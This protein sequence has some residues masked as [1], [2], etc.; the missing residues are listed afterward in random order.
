MSLTVYLGRRS[1]GTLAPTD[2]TGQ[3]SFTYQAEAIDAADNRLS[4]SLPVRKA[5]FSPMESRPFF[6]GLLPERGVR[7]TIAARLRVSAENSYRLLRELGR[8]CAGAVVVL[9]EE[10]ALEPAAGGVEW[11][12]EKDLVAL[13]EEL[14]R[15]PL[16]VSGDRRVRLSLAGLQRKAVLIR[17]A[18]GEFGLP[19]EDAPST[20]LLK[21]EYADSPYPDLVANEHFCMRVADCAGFPAARSELLTIEGRSC[22]LVERFDRTTDGLTTVRV[23][24]EDMCQALGRLPS[25]KYEDEGGPGFAQICELLREESRRAGQDVLTFVRSAV[26]NFLLGNADAHAKN[27]GLLYAENGVQLAPIYDVVSTAIYDDVDN[28]VAMA[29]GGESD[30]ANVSA[31]AWVDFSQEVGIS[32]AQFE[33]ER[34]AVA[35]RVVACAKELVRVAK[36]EG[37]HRPVCDRIAGVAAT[38]REAFG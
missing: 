12:R 8:D 14:P 36:T 38:R 2:E 21:P 10:E 24:Q 9:P 18:T 37:W 35:D 29:I 30:P 23:H 15:R 4:V 27:F 34:M 16:G 3:Y 26:L 7:E 19:T 28:R 11:L 22:L 25:Q 17:S 6:E 13:I 1:V 31:T 5:E 32:A 20:H 33:R